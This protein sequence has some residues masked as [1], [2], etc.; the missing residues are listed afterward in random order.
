[1]FS[2]SAILKIKPQHRLK[3]FW[4]GHKDQI[5]LNAQTNPKGF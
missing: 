4:D 2:T 1:M 5:T 3:Y